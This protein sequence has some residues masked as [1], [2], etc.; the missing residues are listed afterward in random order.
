MVI[1][2]S[3]AYLILIMSLNLLELVALRDDPQ[4][5]HNFWLISLRQLG[6]SFSFQ[7]LREDGGDKSLVDQS[8]RLN[9]CFHRGRGLVVPLYLVVIVDPAHHPLAFDTGER[10]NCG[11]FD[12]PRRRDQAGAHWFQSK[13]RFEV[14]SST[15]SKHTHILRE[16]GNGWCEV[17]S[18][19]GLTRCEKMQ[20]IGL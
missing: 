4:R 18:P 3:V 12:T 5:D 10:I 19:S 2:Y 11:I 1:K 7:H 16:W 15:S 9:L 20:E 14:M 6:D 8:R 17:Q 13:L